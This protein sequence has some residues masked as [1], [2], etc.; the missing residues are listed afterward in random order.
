MKLLCRGCKNELRSFTGQFL[1]NSHVSI[2]VTPCTTCIEKKAKE[3]VMRA[4][5]AAIKDSKL[6]TW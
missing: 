1:S 4:T 3:I 6:D 5:D 2:N